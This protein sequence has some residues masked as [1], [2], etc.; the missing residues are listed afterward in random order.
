MLTEQYNLNKNQA[1]TAATLNSGRA[2]RHL[3][4]RPSRPPCYI[5]GFYLT[6]HEYIH[7]TINIIA[8]ITITKIHYWCFKDDCGYER[9]DEFR[10]KYFEN[11]KKTENRNRQYI[12]I[13][14]TIK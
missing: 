5:T 4:F 11:E 7:T 12:F 2:G 3:K 9:E 13:I 14:L 1:E 10:E 8:K 6:I